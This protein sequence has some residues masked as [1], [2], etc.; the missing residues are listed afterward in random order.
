MCLTRR[1]LVTYVAYIVFLLGRA[2]PDME[3]FD[4]IEY[5]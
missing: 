5:W 4:N 1:F 2:S 3:G